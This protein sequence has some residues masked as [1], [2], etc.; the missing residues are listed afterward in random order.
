MFESLSSEELPEMAQYE[1][2]EQWRDVQLVDAYDFYVQF[3]GDKY[4]KSYDEWLDS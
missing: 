1:A 3:T 4:I 2:R